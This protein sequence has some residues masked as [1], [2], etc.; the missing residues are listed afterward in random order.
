MMP[1]R[2]FICRTVL[3]VAGLAT[4]PVAIAQVK[5]PSLWIAESEPSVAAAI[6]LL[7][8]QSGFAAV[9]IFNCKQTAIKCLRTETT[10]PTV[11]VTDYWS[12]QMWGDEFVRLARHASPKS[13]VILFSG[14]VGNVERWITVAG[15][16]TIQPHA[17]VEKPNSQDLVAAFY[18]IR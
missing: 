2:S 4:A 16:N 13:K 14:V 8:R 9:R 5:L 18:Q 11:L 15:V 12:G 3:G 7:A 1:R 17:F 6:R 10:K